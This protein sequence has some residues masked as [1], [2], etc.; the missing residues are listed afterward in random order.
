MS[1]IRGDDV[2]EQI[3]IDISEGLIAHGVETPESAR[4]AAN[5]V[6]KL[7]R[8]YGGFSVYFQK[9]LQRNLD[10]RDIEIF[11]AFNGANY[12]DLA[13]EHGLTE[14]RVRQ[15]VAK[16]TQTRKDARKT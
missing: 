1:A 14:V 10:K 4:I 9:D 12:G 8:L 6:Q 11:N 7:R 15:I 5:T 16:V 3:G 13:R 2:L